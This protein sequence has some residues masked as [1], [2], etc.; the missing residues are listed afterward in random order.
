MSFD[1]KPL[2][3]DR[4]TVE[5]QS[6]SRQELQVQRGRHEH[7]RGC[8]L[9]PNAIQDARLVTATHQEPCAP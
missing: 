9:V 6:V 2:P 7:G 5:Q 3:I 1:H 8:K 4:R